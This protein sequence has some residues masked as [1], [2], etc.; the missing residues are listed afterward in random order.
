MIMY[1]LFYGYLS[2]SRV[3][4]VRGQAKGT[5]ESD[6]VC[7]LV[8]SN[9]WVAM[10]NWLDQDPLACARQFFHVRTVSFPAR[11]GT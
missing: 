1:W 7:T 10:T 4:A 5:L 8:V 6:S 3:S 9:L 2:L 11:D